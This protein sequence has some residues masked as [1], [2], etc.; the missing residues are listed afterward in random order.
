[1]TRQQRQPECQE[2]RGSLGF[3][4]RFIILAGWLIEKKESPLEFDRLSATFL[5]R[6]S[7]PTSYSC[8]Q[9]YSRQDHGHFEPSLDTVLELSAKFDRKN[10]RYLFFLRLR[11]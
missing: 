11:F 6:I 9:E 4:S 7:D 10:L 8:C 5:G 2:E 1:M 3:T